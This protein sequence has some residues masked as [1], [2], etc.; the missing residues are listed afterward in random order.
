MGDKRPGKGPKKGK[1]KKAP[2]IEMAKEIAPKVP[3]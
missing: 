2:A 1:E 3:K